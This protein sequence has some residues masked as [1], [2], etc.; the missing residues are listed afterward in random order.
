MIQAI[1]HH[2]IILQ[3]CLE[4]QMGF[5]DYPYHQFLMLQ[6]G[7]NSEAGQQSYSRPWG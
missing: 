2:Q 3:H 1:R 5:I 4:P 6:L 7:Q